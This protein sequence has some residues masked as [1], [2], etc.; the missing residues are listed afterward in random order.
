MSD[1][2]AKQCGGKKRFTSERKA[3]VAARR[4]QTKFGSR[5]RAYEC[6]WCKGWHVGTIRSAE[7][8]TARL[9]Q[10]LE[11]HGYGEVQAS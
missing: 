4:T 1:L 11:E 3:D 8:R 7:A 6:P 2:A 10:Q 5:M 9:Q